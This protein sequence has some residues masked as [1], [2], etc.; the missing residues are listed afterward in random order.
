MMMTVL[1]CGG[2][3]FGCDDDS[4]DDSFGDDYN[5]MMTML[6]LVL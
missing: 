6:L 1:Y 2:G 5:L 4:F 3:S